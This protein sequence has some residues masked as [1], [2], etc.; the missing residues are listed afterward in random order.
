MD[1]YSPPDKGYPPEV[2]GTVWQYYRLRGT[3]VDFVTSVGR[4]TI[5][6]NTQIEGS[7]QETSSCIACR[8]RATIG[9]RLDDIHAQDGRPLYP[10][11]S[12]VPPSGAISRPPTA[13]RDYPFGANR[14]TVFE[15]IRAMRPFPTLP[16][17][18]PKNKDRTVTVIKGA[19][20]ARNP[21]LIVAPGTARSQYM[22]L[23][24]VWSLRRAF[25]FQPDKCPPT[26]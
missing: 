19:V 20:G 6:G 15:D 9:R 25:R 23:D 22:Q 4:P 26:E 16:A 5:L 1:R 21:S 12:S 3:Q 8:A 24:F 7:F 2:E 14:L 10:I 13:A 17:S 11:G 18:D